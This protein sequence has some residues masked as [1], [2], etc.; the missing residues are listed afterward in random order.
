MREERWEE[1]I[2]VWEDMLPFGNPLVAGKAMYWRA[3]AHVQLEQKDEALASLDPAA[4]SLPVSY[5]G[6]LGEQLRAR[7]EG[8]DDRASQ[9]WWPPKAG[10]YDDAPRVQIEDLNVRKLSATTRRR[11]ARVR[12]LAALDE[13]RLARQEL[14]PIYQTVLRATPGE[15]TR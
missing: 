15:R 14:S 6:V 2:G 11:W 9:V 7:I 5:Y 8:K 10:T 3:H 4:R 1:A 12:E 13:K